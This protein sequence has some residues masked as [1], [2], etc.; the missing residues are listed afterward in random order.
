MDVEWPDLPVATNIVEEFDEP[1]QPKHS[2]DNQDEDHKCIVSN[3]AQANMA[4]AEALL[5]IQDI[6][7]CMSAT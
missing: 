1:V 3:P 2:R 5:D 4:Q 6:Y 7:L